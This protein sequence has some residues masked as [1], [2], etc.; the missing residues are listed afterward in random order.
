MES[1]FWVMLFKIV[2]FLPLIICMVIISLKLSAKKLQNFQNG[3]YIKVLERN[4]VSKENSLLVVKIGEKTY[5]LSST[6]NKIEILME[7]QEADI[8]SLEASYKV[9]E[10]KSFKELYYKLVNKKEDKNALK[11]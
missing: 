8:L 7:L 1:D 9:P 5:V 10:Y 3:K 4:C 11:K 6:S 2:I